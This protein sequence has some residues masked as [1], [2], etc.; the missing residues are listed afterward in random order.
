V[1]ARNKQVGCSPVARLQDATSSFFASLPLTAEGG[2]GCCDGG[3]SQWSAAQQCGT[4]KE[5]RTNAK[6][7]PIITDLDKETGEVKILEQW[8]ISQKEHDDMQDRLGKEMIVWSPSKQQPK[9]PSNPFKAKFFSSES[10]ALKSPEPQARIEPMQPVRK[11]VCFSP[12]TQQ[13]TS[14]PHI[15]CPPEI[16]EEMKRLCRRFSMD[17]RHREEKKQ[18]RQKERSGTMTH[19]ERLTLAEQHD[20]IADEGWFIRNKG[21]IDQIFYERAMKQERGTY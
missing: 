21:K 12:P 15:P 10:E 5:K 16:L 20:E 6:R 14:E 18:L 13:E 19:M 9:P 7:S 3:N 17:A 4:A 2:K 8:Q 1:R 11:E